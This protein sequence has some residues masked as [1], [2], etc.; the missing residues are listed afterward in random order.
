MPLSIWKNQF[1]LEAMYSTLTSVFSLVICNYVQLVF[2]GEYVMIFHQQ[3]ALSL[4]SCTIW[5]CSTVDA[6]SKASMGSV[7]GA[8]AS[9][10]HMHAVLMHWLRGNR[11]RFNLPLCHAQFVLKGIKL[12]AGSPVI[13]VI[14]ELSFASIYL[15]WLKLNACSQSRY[16][17]KFGEGEKWLRRPRK[18]SR[19]EALN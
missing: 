2:S 3:R 10:C 12:H 4:I 17:Y 11:Q 16:I 13:K 15:E 6:P 18:S 1:Y 14:R 8:A 9:S 19:N 5:N 7:R